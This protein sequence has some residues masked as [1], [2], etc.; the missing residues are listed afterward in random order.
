MEVREFL[1]ADLLLVL[2][3]FYP[4]WGKKTQE[5]RAVTQWLSCGSC[6]VVRQGEVVV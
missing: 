5:D 6:L 1:F 4:T 2:T 3:E